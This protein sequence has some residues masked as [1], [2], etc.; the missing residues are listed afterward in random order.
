MTATQT[1]EL[2][3]EAVA[4]G[5]AKGVTIALVTIKGNGGRAG[6]GALVVADGPSA[7]M[8]TIQQHEAAALGAR[9]RVE[10]LAANFESYRDIQA[11]GELATKADLVSLFKEAHRATDA[12]VACEASAVG[13]ASSRARRSPRR[14]TAPSSTSRSRR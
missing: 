9:Q 2:L 11:A 4:K 12:V 8:V 7:T 3:G 10:N 1:Q 14:P 6:A 13:A 5:V